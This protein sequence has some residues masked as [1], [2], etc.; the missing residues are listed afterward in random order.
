[1]NNLY[2]IETDNN[3]ILNIKVNELLKKNN[4]DPSYL[5]T[6]DMEEVNISD[7]IF[8]LDTYSLFNEQKIVL[9]KNFTFLIVIHHFL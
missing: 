4:L 2:F 6:Y 1:M 7:A 8:D 9:C 3:E 5:I